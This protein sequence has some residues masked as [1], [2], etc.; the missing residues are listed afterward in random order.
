MKQLFNK[1]LALA[2]ICVFAFQANTAPKRLIINKESPTV[3]LMENDTAAPDENGDGDY[4]DDDDLTPDPDEVEDTTD[5]AAKYLENVE[6]STTDI[7]DDFED[8]EY[9]V[10][11]VSATAKN[12]YAYDPVSIVCSFYEENMQ[13]TCTVTSACGDGEETIESEAFADSHGSLSTVIEIDG[14]RYN[15][16]D[17]YKPYALAKLAGEEPE[18]GISLHIFGFIVAAICAIVVTY[19]IVTETA[20]QIKAEKNLEENQ[21]LEETYTDYLGSDYLFDQ[22]SYV[23]AKYNFGFTSFEETGCEVAAVYN[24]LVYRN[25]GKPLSEVIY[26]FENWGIEVS[27]AW[28][29]WGSNPRQIYVALK[30]YGIGYKSYSFAQA[31]YSPKAVF[32]KKVNSSPSGTSF[33]TSFWN[34]PFTEGIH[35]IFVIKRGAHSFDGCNVSNYVTTDFEP[36]TFMS[37]FYQDTGDFVIGYVIE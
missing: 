27:V 32:L 31:D 11:T 20:E 7:T 2:L 28:G 34:S 36:K 5:Y 1:F 29:Y 23:A 14:V 21:K 4:D 22:E 15:I 10:V 19:V 16:S 18:D 17:F 33:I 30:K 26:D 25:E 37:D 35:T 6:I 3:P 8:Q 9:I 12:E 13:Y 24:L